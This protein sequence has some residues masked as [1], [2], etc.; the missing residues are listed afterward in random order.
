M[1][2]IQLV[3]NPPKVG[4]FPTHT[5]MSVVERSVN[6]AALESTPRITLIWGLKDPDLY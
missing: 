2:P 1:F 4:Y 5:H 6:I 3:K